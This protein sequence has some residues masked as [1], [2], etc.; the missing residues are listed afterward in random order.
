MPSDKPYAT[1]HLGVTA[2]KK[3][4]SVD[5][6]ETAVV[7]VVDQQKQKQSWLGYLWDTAD[8]SKEERKLLFKVCPLLCLTAR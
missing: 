6:Q 2:L 5:D 8:L 4:G 7:Q 1:E 3:H